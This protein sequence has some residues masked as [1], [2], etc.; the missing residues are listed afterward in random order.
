MMQHKKKKWKLA[1]D[2]TIG[3]CTLFA[4]IGIDPDKTESSKNLIEYFDHTLIITMS[5]QL[6]LKSNAYIPRFVPNTCGFV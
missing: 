5:S 2:W 4:A 3:W 1:E 6:L